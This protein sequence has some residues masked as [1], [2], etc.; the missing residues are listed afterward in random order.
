M[1]SFA[2]GTSYL[3]SGAAMIKVTWDIKVGD[4]VQFVPDDQPDEMEMRHLLC[5]GSSDSI[6]EYDY[7]L[8][9]VVG[10]VLSLTNKSYGEAICLWTNGKTTEVAPCAMAHVRLISSAG[11]NEQ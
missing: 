4:L 9:T 6:L 11:K 10:V 3:G 2:R 5:T 1:A 8:D 7:P